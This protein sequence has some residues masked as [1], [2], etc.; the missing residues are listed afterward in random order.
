[1]QTNCS[2]CL[3]LLFVGPHAGWITVLILSA[4]LLWLVWR[5]R[6]AIRRETA[7]IC[8][9]TIEERK[10]QHELELINQYFSTA[11]S[12]K[13]KIEDVLWD[14]TGNLMRMLGYVD[15]MI[16]LWNKDRT[17]MVQ[18][19]AFGPKGSPELLASHI[20]E[21][22]PG[23]GVVGYVMQTR[24]PVLIP[25]T[26]KDPRYRA[27]EMFRL[28]E[29]CVPVMHEGEL[30]GIIDSEHHK[31]NYFSERDLKILH[32]I[33]T[34]IGSKVKQLEARDQSPEKIQQELA[35]L[36][37]QLTETQLDILRMQMN[38][39][40]IFNALNSIKRMIMDDDNDGA[41]R[42]LS[43]F[44][45]LVRA[46]LNHSRED[47]VSLR[48][49]TG[50]LRAYLE[51]EQLRFRDVFSYSIDVQGLREHDTLI[52]SLVLQPLVENAILHGLQAK[53]ETGRLWIRFRAENGWVLCEVEDDGVGM[54]DTEIKQAQFGSG[55]RS[56]GLENLRSRIGILDK[57]YEIGL[58]LELHN[59]RK[60]APHLTGMLAILKFR[61]CKTFQH[62][63]IDH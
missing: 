54:R 31:L 28:S 62:E 47:F 46:T 29:I 14:V 13:G 7:L 36:N 4:V 43:K 33:S 6:L 37:L 15:C 32:T 21:V 22:L 53:K 27:D 59:R 9:L 55:H 18:K 44:A 24:K 45:A 1:M 25:D 63:Y 40:F 10:H 34:L 19:A 39:H 30:L 26:R 60:T 57:K 52:P 48:E 16:Y 8:R 17:K 61:L 49:T 42:Y 11:F 5:L 58:S 51:M 3:L 50:H 20:F 38:P 35:Y 12:N 23:Q 2:I 56:V 41:S